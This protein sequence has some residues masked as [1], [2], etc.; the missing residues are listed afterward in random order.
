MKLFGYEITRPKIT[1]VKNIADEKRPESANIHG[2]ILFEQTLHRV[3]QDISTWRAALLSA[4]SIQYPNRTEL[5]RIYKDVMNDGH[6]HSLIETRKQAI[7]SSD[8]IAVTKK[9][10]EKEDK[11]AFIQAKW[12]YDF[13]SNA[14]DSLFYGHSLIQFGDLKNDTFEDVELI[15]R[16]YVKPEFHIVVSNPSDLTGTDYLQAPFDKWCIAVGDKRSLGL[17]NKCVPY[18]IW[19][20]AAMQSWAVFTQRFGAPLMVGKTNTRDEVTRTNMGKML[21]NLEAA[22][23]GVVDTDDEIEYQEVKNTDVHEVFKSLIELCNSEMSKLILGQT[24]TTDI[25]AQVGTA[26]VHE[27]V[28]K[29]VNFADEIFIENIFKYQLVPF[30]NMHNLGFQN[31]TIEKEVDND[32]SVLERANIALQLLGHFDIAPEWVE[33]H[34]NIPVQK[35]VLV[36]G[37]KPF[38]S[39]NPVTDPTELNPTLSQVEDSLE[40]DSVEAKLNLYYGD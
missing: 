36:D 37:K 40:A 9:G 13:T 33:K 26:V 39:E 31:L 19:K 3:N 5:Y 30:L 11:T 17:L 18:F 1:E 4:E 32:L 25:K 7:L 12:F 10:K 6:L 2:K 34:F 28:M 20:R 23:W 15:P 16:H 38:S 8:F 14:L 35:K 24:S 21:Q 27:R 22:G 29:Q